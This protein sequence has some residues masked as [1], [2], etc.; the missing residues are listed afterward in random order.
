MS[1]KI[2]TI[3]YLILTASSTWACNL[4][5]KDK[6][7]YFNPVEISSTNTV[8]N[9]TDKSY[10]DTVLYVG[11]KEANVNN[12]TVVIE[13]MK[14]Q[15]T[16]TKDDLVLDAYVIETSDNIFYVVI[17]D[18]D[19]AKSISAISHE[20]IHIQQYISQRLQINRDGS[21]MWEDMF[22]PNANDIDYMSRPWES[23]AF[24]QQY[25]MRDQIEQELYK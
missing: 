7:R 14:S 25:D 16:S 19:R 13:D 3:G 8:L 21:V 17:R 4:F 9:N 20:I 24:K 5:K 18:M 11:L 12:I 1:M 2:I 23:E 10:L 6:D 15:P 22:I